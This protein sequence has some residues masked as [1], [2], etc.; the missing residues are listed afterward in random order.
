M[1]EGD[2]TPLAVHMHFF[3]KICPNP[4]VVDTQVVW[5]QIG[6]SQVSANTI[7]F[8]WVEYLNRIEDPCV[9][10]A[11]YSERIFDY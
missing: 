8:H 6:D 9:E 11:R 10:I 2:H 3:K 7:L 4:T 5:D 1:P